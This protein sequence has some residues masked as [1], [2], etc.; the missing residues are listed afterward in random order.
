VAVA[1]VGAGVAPWA[2]ILSAL[3]V[4]LAQ[5]G[6]VG[7]SGLV[8]SPYAV[9]LS[10][11]LAGA[12][13][14]SALFAAWA[15]RWGSQASVAAYLALMAAILVQGVASTSPLMVVSDAVF[16][17]N[18]LAAVAG[19][20]LF[21]TSRTQHA[22]PFVI[23][24]GATFYLPLVPLYR[25]G[26]DPVWLVRGG[27][28]VSGIV[29]S[30]ALFALVAARRTPLVAG[31][32]VVWLQLL[33]GTFDVYSYGNL[34]NVFGQS[35]TALFFAWWAGGRPGGWPAG[36]LALA[37][38]AT[39]HLSSLVVLAAVAAGLL[40]ARGRQSLRDR[41]GLVAAAVGLACALVYYGQYWSL[42][43]DQLPRLLEGGGQGR[44][45]W[46]GAWGA[47]RT[48][49]VG[50]L[51]QWGWPTLLLAPFGLPRPSRSR[52]EGDLAGYGAGCLA[53]SLAAVFSP[54]DVRYLY[55]LAPVLAIAAAETA[56]RSLGSG[57]WRRLAVFCVGLWAAVAA[58]GWLSEALTHR[59]R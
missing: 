57:A 12:A 25:L 32:A 15:R 48:Q 47:L 20:D 2:A 36:A 7:P 11:L 56:T 22:Q 14:V 8:R 41:A 23:P 42:I 9:T 33:P 10:L 54:V 58:A 18:K 5:A 27:A 44:G 39:A 35:L 50:A 26:L 38:G 49:L 46:V 19:G 24:Y 4:T 6:L 51:A 17:A 37:L 13:G 16:H 43:R 1:A 53:L 52:W 21:P 3:V 34:S 30:G 59:Y 31:L 29:A 40:L 55:A 45:P 28:A